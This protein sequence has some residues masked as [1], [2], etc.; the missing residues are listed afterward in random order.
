MPLADARLVPQALASG[1]PS[2]W[3]EAARRWYDAE[4]PPSG[5][6]S[7]KPDSFGLEPTGAGAAGS[8]NARFEKSATGPNL[9]PFRKAG[10]PS[11]EEPTAGQRAAAWLHQTA[12]NLRVWMPWLASKA[13]FSRLVRYTAREN[14]SGQGWEIALPR[15]CWA[16]GKKDD[17]T[18]S[19]DTKS[20][21]SVE[22]PHGFV[23]LIALGAFVALLGVVLFK[24]WILL[25]GI[26]I[27]ALAGAALWLRSYPEQARLAMSACPEHAERPRFPDVVVYDNELHVFAATPEL[28]KA[29][30]IEQHEQRVTGGRGEVHTRDSSRREASDR[31]SPARDSSNRPATRPE[32]SSRGS[33]QPAPR[34]PKKERDDAPYEAPRIPVRQ[35]LPPIKL[36]GDD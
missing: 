27:G 11:L 10:D 31:E 30:K 29:A 9:A 28:A 17:L 26:V 7:P 19:V 15:Q 25:A 13:W 22:Q 12:V 21:R 20:V 24:L 18:S 33:G 16:C 23:L 8:E 3:R 14:R 4:M 5:P 36:D 35:E 32:D 1:G 6:E 34:V 2:Y